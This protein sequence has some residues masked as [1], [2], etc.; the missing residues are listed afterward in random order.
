MKGSKLFQKIT[1]NSLKN[2]FNCY[3]ISNLRKV[4]KK[5]FISHAVIIL[6][7]IGTNMSSNEEQGQ[8]CNTPTETNNSAMIETGKW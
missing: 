3:F 5:L 7:V 4:I 8:V 2:Q 1:I 6:F